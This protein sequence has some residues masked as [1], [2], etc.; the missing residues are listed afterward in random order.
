[1]STVTMSSKGQV[2]IPAAVRQALGLKEGAKLEITTEGDEAV[3]RPLR[4]SGSRKSWKSWRGSLSGTRA[5]E[6]HL[7]E[8]RR[9]ASR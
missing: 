9:D 5:L 6:E 1:M 7:A 3:L 4:R 2:V 8:H